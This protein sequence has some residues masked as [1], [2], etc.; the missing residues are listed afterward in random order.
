M[1]C[2]AAARAAPGAR[3]T[4][5]QIEADVARVAGYDALF[6]APE[7]RDQLRRVLTVYSQR[8]PRVGYCQTMHRLAAMLLTRLPEEEA[9][10]MLATLLNRV[11]PRDYLTDGMRGL[12]VDVQVVAALARQTL[13][14]LLAALDAAGV[15]LDG[16]LARWLP[17][18]Y[19]GSV[20]QHVAD[21]IFDLVTYKGFTALFRITLGLLSALADEIDEL[22]ARG[23]SAAPGDS[24][25]APPAGAGGGNKE[26]DDGGDENDTAA[27]ADAAAAAAASSTSPSDGTPCAEP[28][29]SSGDND[30]DD[31]DGAGCSRTGTILAL[32]QS[33][34]E[35][36]TEADLIARTY[37]VHIPSREKIDEMRR[38]AWAQFDHDTPAAPAAAA[39]AAAAPAPAPPSLAPLS[40]SSPAQHRPAAPALVLPTNITIIPQSAEP[41][42]CPGLQLGGPPSPA[43]P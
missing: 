33:L 11:M 34:P 43:M 36:I 12:L 20:S 9:Y 38:A 31:D 26:E 4:L 16:F 2:A 19:L 8:H 24:D 27:R 3:P 6:A 15:A 13:P 14:R 10:W 40:P 22:D 32:L 28:H 30:D 17:S 41:L 42:R 1:L 35:R 5:A 37:A 23:R 39:A 21:R 29:R 7:G 18:L 25:G